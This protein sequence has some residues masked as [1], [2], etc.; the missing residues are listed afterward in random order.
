M[1]RR[2]DYPSRF[3]FFRRAAFVLVRD[4]GPQALSRRSVAAALGLSVN[5]VRR[6]LADDADLRGLALDEV[7]RRQR[8]RH[9]R[10]R[11]GLVGRELALD[12]LRS[13]L[14]DEEE[15]TPEALVWLRLAI[16]AARLPSPDQDSVAALRAEHAIAMRGYV[17]DP[18]G[19]VG[20]AGP[21]PDR[22]VDR[23]AERL[24]DHGTARARVV[25]GALA[26]LGV[27][28]GPEQRRTLALVDGLTLGTCLGRTTPDEAVATLEHHVATLATAPT[29]TAAPAPTGPT[30][31]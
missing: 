7:E 25:D 23:L 29:D 1:P 14:P 17:D 10:R 19:D 21:G 15:L 20:T 24:A 11:R 26:A 22:L 3:E 9:W 12:L 2:V 30:T 8:A 18:V 31:G 5:G 13:L 16:D 4:Q 27:T 6:V 28:D